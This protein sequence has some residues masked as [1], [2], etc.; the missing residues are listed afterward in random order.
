[1]EDDDVRPSGRLAGQAQRGLDRLAAGVGEEQRVQVVRQHRAEPL[2]ELEQWPMHD[3]GVL[4]VDQAGDLGLGRRNHVRVAVPGAGH[5]DARGEVE[6]AA[7]VG[8]VQV[9]ARA[10]VD[11][12]RG[13]LLEDGG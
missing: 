1:M 7:S 10:V 12:Y 4:A 13:G 6:I 9:A 11:G 5:A 3:G 2:G 8:A